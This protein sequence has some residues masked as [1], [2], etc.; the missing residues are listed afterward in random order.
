VIVWCNEIIKYEGLGEK[1]C[2][3]LQD[4]CVGEMGKNVTYRLEARTGIRPVGELVATVDHEE[5]YCVSREG[6]KKCKP[7]E[8]I[9]REV[10]KEIIKK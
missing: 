4:G 8:D 5:G 2:L 10:R 3:H 7:R 9:R 6:K 1:Y